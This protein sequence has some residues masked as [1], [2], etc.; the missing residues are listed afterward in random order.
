[1][2]VRRD[3]RTLL[4]PNLGQD[5]THTLFSYALIAT[6]FWQ[7]FTNENA[8]GTK[9]ESVNDA[10]KVWSTQQT[11]VNL[12]WTFYFYAR[13]HVAFKI[14]LCSSWQRRAIWARPRQ[15]TEE[16]ASLEMST[17]DVQFPQ[18][19][20]ISFHCLSFSVLLAQ[21]EA[22]VAV[23]GFQYTWVRVIVHEGCENCESQKIVK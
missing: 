7:T 10:Q 21:D 15:A 13:F 16:Q 6:F 22:Q 3:I 11:S 14:S 17:E 18:E 12:D 2:M 23:K 9:I 20:I 4:R 5:P 8:D 19:T 1:M